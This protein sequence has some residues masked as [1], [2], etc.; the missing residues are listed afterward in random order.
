[1]NGTVIIGV[2]GA[3]CAIA[4]Q[5]GHSLGHDVLAVNSAGNGLEEKSARHRLCLD[6]NSRGGRLPTV[7]TAEAAAGEAADEF[8]KILAGNR[9]VILAVG[10]GGA[11]GSGAAPKLAGIA[12]TVGAHVTAVATLPFSFEE[13]RRAVAEAAL[14]K[15]EEHAD[16]L[17]LHDHSTVSHS[18]SAVQ[19]SL[20]EYFDR[21]AS[22]LSAQLPKACGG[23]DSQAR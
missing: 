15:L 18:K 1:M 14:L 21:L 11:T 17:I 3:G 12:Q 19:E 22:E 2:G 7:V 6:I 23:T 5:L 9:R 8:R 4:E 10:L 13:R 20:N 16:V